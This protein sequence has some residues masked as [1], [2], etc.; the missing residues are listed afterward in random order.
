MIQSCGA[1]GLPTGGLARQ[2]NTWRMDGL[3]A[4]AACDLPLGLKT[5]LRRSFRGPKTCPSWGL[6][7]ASSDITPCILRDRGLRKPRISQI[8]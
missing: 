7:A 2:R 8:G 5:G 4:A 3:T 1:R 6:A